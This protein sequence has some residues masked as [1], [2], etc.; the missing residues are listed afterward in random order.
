MPKILQNFHEST[1]IW[2]INKGRHLIIT[3]NGSDDGFSRVITQLNFQ[4]LRF[5]I[6]FLHFC[7]P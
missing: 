6:F 1:V 7:F 2:R 4:I 5:L 3:H